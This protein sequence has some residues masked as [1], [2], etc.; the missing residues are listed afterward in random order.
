MPVHDEIK[1]QVEEEYLEPFW[2]VVRG[3]AKDNYSWT[4]T[5]RILGYHCPR[6]FKALMIREGIEID[7]PKHRTC[8]VKK[9]QGESS[10]IGQRKAIQAIMNNPNS[11][12]AKYL[13]KTGESVFELVERLRHHKTAS[14]IARI[15]GW[16]RDRDLRDWLRK[17]GVVVTYYKFIPTPPVGTGWQSSES[18]IAFSSISRMATS[19]N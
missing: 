5:A 19:E 7:W 11:V 8:N 13:Q 1:K 9:N 6:T 4:T 10:L 16:K 17:R 18:R 3:Y 15:A 14:E 12:A 2:D